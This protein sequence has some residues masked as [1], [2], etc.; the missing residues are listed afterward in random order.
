[1]FY[2]YEW[3]IKETGEIIYVGKGCKNRYKSLCHRNKIFLEFIKRFDCDCRIIKTFLSEEDAFRYEKER[4]AQLKANGLCICNLDQGGTG[5]VNFAWTEEMRQYKSKYNPMKSINQRK[6]MSEK[7]PMKNP[8]IAKANGEKKRR[9]VVINNVVYD[10]VK[11]AAQSLN[12]CE[13]SIITWCKRGYDT[14]GNPCRYFNEPQKEYPLIKKTHPMVTTPK[15]VIIDGIRFE[16]VKDG[17]FFIGVCSESII[18]AI[19]C[20]RK[21]KG[22]ECRYDNQQPSHENSEISIVEGSTTNE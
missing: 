19:K 3:F 21:C 4:I 13:F 15:P 11:I 18:R 5:G 20:G 9:K 14:K 12:V 1:M 17:A 16:T 8:S 6:R 10:G 7:N 2:V 22:H